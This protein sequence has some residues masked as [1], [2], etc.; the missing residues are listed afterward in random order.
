MPRCE[1][2]TELTVSSISWIMQRP[3]QRP[4]ENVTP[5]P[6]WNDTARAQLGRV[7]GVMVRMMSDKELARLDVLRDL[8]HWRLMVAAARV[9]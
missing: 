1:V 8:D 5:L 2:I 4:D 7:F 3:L 6:I 9:S